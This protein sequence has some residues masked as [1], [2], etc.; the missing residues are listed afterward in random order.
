MKNISRFGVNVVLGHN[1]MTKKTFYIYCTF[2]IRNRV[3]IALKQND[4][5]QLV[6][7]TKRLSVK[8]KPVTENVNLT[9]K[10]KKQQQGGILKNNKK[11]DCN[12]KKKMGL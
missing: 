2:I 1:V 11:S 12:L 7:H 4:Y 8:L 9:I 10:K 3:K 5:Q 6:L